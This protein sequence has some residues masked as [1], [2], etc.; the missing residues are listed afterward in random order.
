MTR[1]LL[2]SLLNRRELAADWVQQTRNSLNNFAQ[3]TTLRISRLSTPAIAEPETFED[4]HHFRT[5]A[6]LMLSAMADQLWWFT[7]RPLSSGAAGEL[8]VEALA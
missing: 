2:E 6:K 7:Y 3:D 8:K 1:K 5:W 4:N